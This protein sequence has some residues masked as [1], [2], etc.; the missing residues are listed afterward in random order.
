MLP[1]IRV[2]RFNGARQEI[3]VRYEFDFELLWNTLTKK[4]EI[5]VTFETT[6]TFPTVFLRLI[7]GKV[8]VDR[9]TG[10]R[11]ESDIRYEFNLKVVLKGLG[12][13]KRL[14]RLFLTEFSSN[15]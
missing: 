14:F 15:N 13:K 12:C 4:R 6:Y 10:P 3:D 11:W 8:G 9:F 2:Y 7:L 5:I 1:K